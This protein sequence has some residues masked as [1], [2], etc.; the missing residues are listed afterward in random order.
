MLIYSW[1]YIFAPAASWALH[2]TRFACSFALVGS[3]NNR[4][5]Y[6]TLYFIL[7]SLHSRLVP[8]NWERVKLNS[9]NLS[10]SASSLAA[11]SFQITPICLHSQFDLKGSKYVLCYVMWPDTS[12]FFNSQ[13]VRAHRQLPVSLREGKW[14]MKSQANGPEEGQ[15]GRRGEAQWTWK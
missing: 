10:H 4:R 1:I 12:W 15:F 5:S 11:L 8:W 14:E 2:S 13:T 6:Y 7:Y 9:E 3:L